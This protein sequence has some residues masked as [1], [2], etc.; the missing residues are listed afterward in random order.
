MGFVKQPTTWF[1]SAS[2]LYISVGLNWD[3]L[4]LFS[5]LNTGYFKNCRKQII[6]NVTKKIQK[7]EN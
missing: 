5:N 2:F 6:Q 1:D 7:L 4:D 3:T